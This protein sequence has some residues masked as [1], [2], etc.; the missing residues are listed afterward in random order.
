MA[1]VPPP[2]P[3]GMS[4][5]A[6][7]ELAYHELRAVAHRQL[8]KHAN[9]DGDRTLNTTALVHEAYLKL[10]AGSAGTWRDEAHFRAVASVAMRHI[11]VDRARARATERHG[12]G[13]RQ[14]TLDEQAVAGDDDPETLLAI[15]AACTKLAETSP[16]LA[17][18]VELRFFAAL[19]E[20][21]TA[22]ELGVTVRTVQRDWAKARGILAATLA[23]DE[24]YLEQPAPVRF[25]SLLDDRLDLEQ[26]RAA[27]GER[28]EIENELGAGGMAVIYRARD[29]RDRRVVALKVLRAMASPGVAARF[30]RE[31]ALASQLRHSRIVPL[32]DSGDACDRLW[33]AMPFVGGE[34]L[35]DRV[36]REGRLSIA[37]TLA[38]L[39]DVADALDYAHA[40]GVVHRDLKPD[41][42]MLHD[43]GALVMDFGVAKAI[44]DAT[45][46]VVVRDGLRTSTGVAIG[47]PA[48]MSPEQ[49]AG[50][51]TVDHRTDLYALGII[52]YELLTG[53]PPFTAASRQGMMTAHLAARPK[54]LSEHR[55]DVPAALESLVMQLLAKRADDRLASAHAVIVAATA[56]A[57]DGVRRG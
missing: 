4:L 51:K 14:V 33:Y 9:G 22:A 11:L 28:Y 30:R 54:R 16:R 6:L 26:F 23:D 29:R 43:S 8:N 53:S 20:S 27:L 12:G 24:S 21:E 2:S 46:G 42:I 41:N 45:V 15:D 10:A 56:I 37:G 44:S 32:L 47:T 1:E 19:S 7:T 57:D 5:D 40:R 55:R 13:L 25:A 39:R 17:R 18:L 34:S 31:I 49:A 35:R 50:E 36:R 3:A 48:Y 38:I 52:A